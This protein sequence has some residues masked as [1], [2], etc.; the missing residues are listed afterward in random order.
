MKYLSNIVEQDHCFGKKITRPT[1]GFKA[2]HSTTAALAGIDV[3]YMIAKH[4]FK[5]NYSSTF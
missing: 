4:Q 2:L 3:A 5:S 1:L